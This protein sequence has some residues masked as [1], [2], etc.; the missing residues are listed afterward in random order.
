MRIVVDTNVLLDLWVFADPAVVLLRRLLR[1]RRVEPLASP[2][3]IEE[4]T[5]VL[6]RP[7]FGLA[8][9]QARQ[10]LDDWQTRTVSVA[11]FSAREGCSDPQDQKFVDLAVS[12]NA[13][14]L[15]TRDRALLRMQRALASAGVRVL[16]PGPALDAQ[17]QAGVD[18]GCTALAA[19]A[20]DQSSVA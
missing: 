11:V 1:E 16:A 15:V 4:L 17:L 13:R 18:A 19:A 3:C 5:D 14:L 7:Q 12:G 8:P 20:A 2:A 10:L 6:S 9:Q